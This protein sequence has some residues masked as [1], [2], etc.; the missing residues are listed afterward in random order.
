MKKLWKVKI[1][2]GDGRTREGWIAA[3]GLLEATKMAMAEN[4]EIYDD[5]EVWEAGCANQV[6]WKV[7]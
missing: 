2:E 5:P 7:Q 4:A 1:L 6:F 3:G